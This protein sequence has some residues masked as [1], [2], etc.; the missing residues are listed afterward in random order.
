MLDVEK[1]GDLV[2]IDVR[3]RALRGEH[4]GHEVMEYIKQAPNNL[5]IEVHVPHEPTPLMMKLEM[6][7]YEMSVNKISDEHFCLVVKK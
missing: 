4:P 6:L 1:I 5:T 7:G 2:K 3:E